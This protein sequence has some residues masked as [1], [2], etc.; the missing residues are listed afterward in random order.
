MYVSSLS[1]L[2]GN[3]WT[4]EAVGVEEVL[5]LV[6]RR[7]GGR[8]LKHLGCEI[9]LASPGPLKRDLNRN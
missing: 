5:P 7:G 9:G 6:L 1:T 3:V 2:S 4:S 8:G